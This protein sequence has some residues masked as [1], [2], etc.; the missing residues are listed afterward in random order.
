[1]RRIER[2]LLYMLIIL[3]FGISGGLLL[4]CTS[5]SG[6]FTVENSLPQEKL[7]HYNDSFDTLREELWD[8]TAWSS[9]E[10]QKE[11]FKLADITIQE[12]QLKI[13]TK[14][15]AFSKASLATR[16]SLGGDFDIQI[17]CHVDF[18][19]G[20]SDMAQ[21]AGLG[22]VKRGKTGKDI[23]MFTLFVRKTTDTGDRVIDAIIFNRGR[24][25]RKQRHYTENFH[26]TLR[27]VRI[28]KEIS[29]LYKKEGQNKWK[30]MCTTSFSD[31]IVFFGFTV[32][33]FRQV[34]TAIKAPAPFSARFDNF[35][36]N[37]AQ[38]II[39]QDI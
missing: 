4:P 10:A 20:I 12:G 23:Q 37:G 28:G 26:G 36:I 31:K 35:K 13:Q 14:T 17:D 3:L 24:F 21:H 27:M 16:Y 34:S 15:G 1:M 19:E 22:V 5:W 2:F 8:R 11:N 29:A 39:E 6:D 32:Q 7:S 33:N 9:K 38:E 30:T 18:L 25:K